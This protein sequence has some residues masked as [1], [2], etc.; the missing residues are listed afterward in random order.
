MIQQKSMVER[1]WEDAKA[2]R[3]SGDVAFKDP[4]NWNA[5]AYRF[6]IDLNNKEQFARMHF[7]ILGQG[8]GFD[9]ADDILNASKV[10]D[11]IYNN[12]L[13]ALNDEA[14]KNP[15]VFGQF[16]TP[17]EFADD[18]LE[19]LD[20]TDKSGWDEVLQRY[21]LKDFKGSFDELKEHVMSALR[22][23]SAQDIREQ[24]KYLNEKRQKPEQRVLGV[25]Y[26]EREEDYK[27]EGS[28]PETELY[29]IFQKSG[30]QGTE[31]EFYDNFFPDLERSDMRL[32]TK[33]GKDTKL[34]SFGLDMQ[35]PFAS[36]GTIESFFDE[37]EPTE[38]EKEADKKRGK[39][40]FTFEIDDDDDDDEWEYR[41]RKKENEVLDEFT[42]MFKGL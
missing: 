37:P 4:I 22:T 2:G 9:A 18:M 6:G 5:Q 1:H 17:E 42:T 16:I 10:K 40:Y 7:Q 21:G 14:L 11:Q 36:L 35:D 26:I 20:P 41:P 38:E 32:L 39:S 29:S 8:K 3:R 31:D 25:T 33:A 13:P 28:K 27:E 24:I 15:T 19:G 34:E 23:G 12:I 30:F